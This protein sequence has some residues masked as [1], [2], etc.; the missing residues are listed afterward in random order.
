MSCPLTWPHRIESNNNKCHHSLRLGTLSELPVTVKLTPLRSGI[1]GE[2]LSLRLKY[3]TGDY[4]YG[5]NA[6]LIGA[7]EVGNNEFY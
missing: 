1:E 7:K 4:I 2:L 5:T 3:Y 6:L